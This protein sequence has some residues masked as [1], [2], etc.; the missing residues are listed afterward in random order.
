MNNHKAPWTIT[1][2]HSKHEREKAVKL[3]CF[4]TKYQKLF[5]FC[6]QNRNDKFGIVTNG[7]TR[8]IWYFT[9]KGRGHNNT[10]VWGGVRGGVVKGQFRWSPTTIKWQS[11]LQGPETI[12]NLRQVCNFDSIIPRHKYPSVPNSQSK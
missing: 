4:I 2:N 8:A 9:Y 1:T 3:C 11:V 6:S 10:W 5:V 12:Y 7:S